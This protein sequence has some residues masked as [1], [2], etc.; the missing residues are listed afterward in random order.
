[1]ETPT[2]TDR[3]PFWHF[4]HQLER[5]LGYE[6]WI[7][8]YKLFLQCLYDDQIPY[9]ADGSSLLK[10]CKVLYLQ[11]QKDENKFGELFEEA[12][13]K[14]HTQLRMLFGNRGGQS[15]GRNPDTKSEKTKSGVAENSG[16]QQ[17]PENA[18]SDASMPEEETDQGGPGK[19]EKEYFITPPSIPEIAKDGNK[20]A[21]TVR[22]GNFNFQDEYL[23]V[24]RREIAKAWQYLRYREKGKFT[25]EVNIPA[26]VK[27]I[28]KEMLFTEPEYFPGKKNRNNTAILFIDCYGSMTPFHELS[29]RL[30]DIGRRQ[31]GHE[32]M[33]AYYFQNHPLGYVF[34]K[35][36][37]TQPRKIV[38]ALAKS[39]SYYTKAIIISDAGF[40][41]AYG[42]ED[43]FKARMEMLQP[44]F[45][46]LK[47]R[48]AD[49][50][51][52]NP[53]PENRWYQPL[54]EQIGN[55]GIAMVSINS[56]GLNPF[57]N[58]LRAVITGRV[59]SN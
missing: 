57:Q 29:R 58:A 13:E 33:K 53:M 1:M 12:W 22:R 38:E 16:E 4:F 35:S 19:A 21:E 52:F 46:E 48:C 25:D 50:I 14:E 2:Q 11:D 44:F 8:K 18:D 6:R 39:N 24:T 36:N 42:S 17:Q 41:R 47:P 49:T 59:K 55:A 5:H 54:V 37:L 45:N 34:E 15:G 56:E 20:A 27:K 9:E 30:L 40:A 23:L 43:R 26:T 10:L 31:G 3:L 7:E 28:A 32:G 51:W